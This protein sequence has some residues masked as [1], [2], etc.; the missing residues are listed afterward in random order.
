MGLISE[1][2]PRATLDQAADATIARIADRSRP[3]LSAVKEYINVAPHTDPLAQARLAANMIS[4]VLG[5]Q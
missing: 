5:S 1:V 4:V 2:A 3:A